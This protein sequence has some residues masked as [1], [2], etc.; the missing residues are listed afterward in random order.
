MKIFQFLVKRSI[1]T[2][3]E[4]DICYSQD[5]IWWK[6][7]LINDCID[8]VCCSLWSIPIVLFT[9]VYIVLRCSSK[10]TLLP[11]TIP[12][13]FYNELSRTGL[14]FRD[15]V[16]TVAILAGFVKKITSCLLKKIKV[17]IHFP[18]LGPVIIKVIGCEI[19]ITYHWKKDVSSAKR[20]EFQD[21]SSD[22]SLIYIKKKSLR[23]LA[24][25][26]A[27]DKAGQLRTNLCF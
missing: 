16:L 22:R 18:L 20:L 3:V 10:S 4:Y 11:K 5:V 8:K 23:A 21:E 2:L 15:S 26:L 13:S 6:I 14:L 19:F 7:S 12:I 17:D 1:T 25:T 9:L 24:R 27:Q